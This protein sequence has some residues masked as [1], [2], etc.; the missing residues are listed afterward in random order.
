[1]HNQESPLSSREHHTPVKIKLKFHYKP[2][3]PRRPLLEFTKSKLVPLAVIACLT[4]CTLLPASKLPKQGEVHVLLHNVK[5]DKTWSIPLETYVVGVVLAELS[6]ASRD[7]ATAK[8]LIE[9]QG[10]VTRTYAISNIGRHADDGY[11]LCDTTHCQ[12]FH[13]PQTHTPELKKLARMAV[14]QTAGKIIIHENSPI[15]ALFHSNCGGHTSSANTI[16]GGTK[17]PYLTARLDSY[18]TIESPSSWQ[19]SINANKLFQ[20]LQPHTTP[21]IGPGLASVKVIERDI[22][23]RNTKIKLNGTHTFRGETF[24]TIIMDNYGA[25]SIR[26][27]RFTVRRNGDTFTFAGTGYGHGAGL[28]QA[29]MLARILDGKETTEILSHYY[30]NTTIGSYQPSIINP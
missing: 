7:P 17:H 10:L 24:R 11:D 9:I 22:A 13:D 23:G 8:R 18:C 28:C 29:G 4:S 20:A 27:T 25:S 5:L 19:W 6:I 14:Y 12:V 21:N 3:V 30:P 26:S 2:A 15:Q 16:W 1:M